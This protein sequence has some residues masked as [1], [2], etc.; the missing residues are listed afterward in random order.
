MIR[1]ARCE[2]WLDRSDFHHNPRKTNGLSS[3]CKVCAVARTRE[4]RTDNRT[5]YTERQRTRYWRNVNA[6]RVRHNARDRKRRGTALRIGSCKGCGATFQTFQPN[7][8][9]CDPSCRSRM[10]WKERPPVSKHIR[11]RV[12]NRD[13]WR[14]YLCSRAIDP[15]LQWPDEWSG[16]ADHVIPY[17]VCQ[18]NR[19]ENLRAAHWACNRTKGDALPGT[20]VWVPAEV[21]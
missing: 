12:L 19:P 13:H 9:W 8:V 7:R 10:K 2:R 15:N 11:R 1:C 20:E 5:A 4:W 16:T 18:H 14:C 21:A 17:S 6:E 3:W